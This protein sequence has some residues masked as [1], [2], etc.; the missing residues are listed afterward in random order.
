MVRTLQEYVTRPEQTVRWQWRVGDL[1]IWDNQAT[2][3]YA[4]R[5]YGTERRRAERLTTIGSVP[6]G[7]DGTP[8]RAVA[9][10]TTAFSAGLGG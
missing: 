9:G 5:D 8:S 4:I 6:V 7:L 1:V 3:H 2:M 10:D